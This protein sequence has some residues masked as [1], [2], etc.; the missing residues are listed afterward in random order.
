MKTTI[1]LL[2]LSFALVGCESFTKETE[3][4]YAVS[5]DAD[6]KAGSISITL[7]PTTPQTLHV[8]PSPVWAMDDA[9]IEKIVRIV[10]AS[11]KRNVPDLA[12]PVAEL[13]GLA[14]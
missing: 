6:Q 11:A 10:E 1:A 3:R 5:Y 14:K 8:A 12:L 13:E 9:T 2:L 4:T 7:K